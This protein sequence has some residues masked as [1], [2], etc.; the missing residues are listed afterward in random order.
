MAAN[1]TPPFWFDKPSL[2]SWLLWPFS[3]LYNRGAT[4]KML[5]TSSS[6]VDVPVL[7]IGNFVAGGGGKTP[8]ALAFAKSLK[9]RGFKP[10]FLSRGYGGRVNVPTLVDT[11]KFNALDVG[12]EPLLLAQVAK[13]VVSADR[14]AGAKLLIKN[15]CNFIVMDDGFQN[16]SLNK[17]FCLVVVDSRRG[18]GNGFTIPAGPLRAGIETQITK[19]DAVLIV[20]D[21]NGA[22]EIIRKTA[23]SGRPVYHSK[24]VMEKPSQW[25]NKSLIAFA[26][27]ADPEKFFESLRKQGAKLELIR[28]FGDHHYFHKDEIL[29][30]LDRAKHLK[31]ELV[32]TAKDYVRFLGMGE[33]HESF[34]KQLFIV[35]VELKFEDKNA[36]NVIIDKTI[37]QFERRNI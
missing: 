32:T 29:E 10:G 2:Q 14:V 37:A 35:H 16:P 6:K 19:T 33:L 22:D 4:F 24:L 13:T 25:R 8:T 5:S 34:A 26:G 27:I 20:G 28:P 31:A 3:Y 11:K 30:M 21:D 9:A 15:G 18:I 12:D 36:I 17:D 23:R 1:E 7:C